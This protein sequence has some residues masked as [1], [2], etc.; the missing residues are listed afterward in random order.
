MVPV[1]ASER[2]FNDLR[3]LY[4]M[5]SYL[6]G[7]VFEGILE[8]D[9]IFLYFFLLRVRMY[10]YYG[11]KYLWTSDFCRQPRTVR[12][13]FRLQSLRGEAS[14]C[15]NVLAA[16]KVSAKH[17]QFRL[18]YAQNLVLVLRDYS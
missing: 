2:L 17:L 13:H 18:P 3:V 16:T 7:G 4:R 9:I 15:G 11:A 5:M 12:G 10:K 14:C 1:A 6:G 8:R